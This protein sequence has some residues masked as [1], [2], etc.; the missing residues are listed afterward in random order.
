MQVSVSIV[1]F[2]TKDLLKQCIENLLNQKTQHNVEIF[3]IDNNSSD[4]SVQM[5]EEN[6]SGKVKLIRNNENVGFA[7]GQNIILKRVKGSYVLILNP[8]TK[9]PPDAIEKMI[10]FMEENPGNGIASC[11]LIGNN[12]KLQ[13]NG[14]DFP[15]GIALISWLFNLEFLGINS[16]FHRTEKNFYDKG[17]EVDWVGGTFM[18][19]RQ[20]VF[21]S[22]GY[23][24][25]DY[26]MYFE[27]AEFCYKASKKRFKVMINPEVIVTHQSGASSKNPRFNQWSGE[28]KGLINFYKKEFGEMISFGLRLM[29]YCAV[30]LRIITFSLLGKFSTA[31]VYAK[32]LGEI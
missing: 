26:F 32:V 11:K 1:S 19:V 20:D 31:K 18:M 10:V 5:I 23:F 24:N 17:R 4:G 21:E 14:G 6:Y 13:S 3:V 29:I 25:E 28:F 22:V 30:L 16:N 7:K 9:I 12:G 15:F 8:D 27:D 2:N